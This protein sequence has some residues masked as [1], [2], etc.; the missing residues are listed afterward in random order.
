MTLSSKTAWETQRTC[1]QSATEDQ[2]AKVL[3]ETVR[4]NTKMTKNWKHILERQFQQKATVPLR[5]GKPRDRFGGPGGQVPDKPASQ[6]VETVIS[7]SAG[8]SKTNDFRR[9]CQQKQR[10]ETQ[11]KRF[12]S[13]LSQKNASREPPGSQDHRNRPDCQL[14]VAFENKN[15]HCLLRLSAKSCV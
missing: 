12:L 5:T 7:N 9:D 6:F 11:R 10:L 3:N 13:R 14:K 1:A 4:K 8:R 15:L 2:K